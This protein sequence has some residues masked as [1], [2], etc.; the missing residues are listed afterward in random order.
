MTVAGAVEGVL[1]LVAVPA[2]LL[3]TPRLDDLLSPLQRLGRGP[4]R[5]WVLSLAVAVPLWVGVGAG[6]STSAS[7]PFAFLLVGG[8][9]VPL[10]LA[11]AWAWARARSF[12]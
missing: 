2:A 4:R 7:R 1:A 10:L 11:C 3:R 12:S 5:W 8:L 9:A 6:L